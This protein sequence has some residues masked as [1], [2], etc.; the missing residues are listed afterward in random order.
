MLTLPWVRNLLYG[1][2]AIMVERGAVPPWRQV[3]DDLRKRIKSGEFV[4]GGP[5]PSLSELA[6]YYR[7]STTTARKAVQALVAEGLVETAPG[8]GTFVR[9]A[10]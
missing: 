7:C 2:V 10:P 1:Y 9:R 6:D 8:W 4:P 5:L 3:A